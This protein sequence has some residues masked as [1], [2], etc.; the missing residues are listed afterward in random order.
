[1][2]L[3]L[4]TWGGGTPSSLEQEAKGKGHSMGFQIELLLFKF[5]PLY[6]GAGGVT[7]IYLLL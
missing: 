2:A 4:V 7:A 1:M 3:L 6:L 5:P